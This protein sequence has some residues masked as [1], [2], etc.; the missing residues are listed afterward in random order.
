MIKR[1]NR[2]KPLLILVSIFVSLILAASAAFF[3]RKQMVHARHEG[4]RRDG[5]AAYDKGE[6]ETAMELLAKVVRR[7]P[8]DGEALLRLAEARRRVPT[9]DGQ[10]LV[11]A[12]QL[13]R[14]LVDLQPDNL[15]IRRELMSLYDQI[16]Y[17]SE[18]VGAAESVLR[19]APKDMQALKVRSKAL[20]ALRRSKEALKDAQ[21]ALAA[22]PLDVE[23]HLVALDVYGDLNQRDQCLP[24]ALRLLKAHG[25][26][27][28]AQLVAGLACTVADQPTTAQLAEIRQWIAAEL[29]E[30][31]AQA[32]GEI[33]L[34]AAAR[35][36]LMKAAQARPPDL[37]FTRLL[38][39]NLERL[40]MPAQCMAV[41]ERAMDEQ[42]DPGLLRLLVRRQFEFNRFADIEKRLAPVQLS[43]KAP[44]DL[45][46]LGIQAAALASL[47]KRDEAR[48]IADSLAQQSDNPSAQAWAVIVKHFFLGLSEDGARVIEVI[49]LA[50]EKARGNGYFWGFLGEAYLAAGESDQ[51]TAS[52][53]QSAEFC[54]LWPQ[55]LLRLSNLLLAGGQ[56][57][58]ALAVAREA[59]ILMPTIGTAANEALV[60]AASLDRA[61]LH[62]EKG[63]VLLV[64]EIQKQAPGEERTLPLHVVLLA[65]TG[66]ADEARKVVADT[67]SRARPPAE[68]T[69]L[70]LASAS[71]EAALGMEGECYAAAEKQ[72]GLSAEQVW[73]R[74]MQ[75]RA[76][77]DSAAGARIIQEAMSRTGKSQDPTWRL[78]WARYL[79]ATGDSRAVAAWTALADDPALAGNIQIQ[80]AILSASS[81]QADQPLLLRTVDRIRAITGEAAEGWRVAKMRVLARGQV[82]PEA[83]AQIM[84]LAKQVL[85]RSPDHLEARLKL[86]AACQENGDIPGAI[87]N[88][89]AAAKVSPDLAA[90]RLNLAA[91]Y[92]ERNDFPRAAEQLDQ[93][94]A[95][96]LDARQ[97]QQFAA[98]LARQGQAGKAMAVLET[99]GQQNAT[100]AQKLMLADLYRRQ[101]QPAKAES[102]YRELLK[103]PTAQ[104]VATAADFFAASG[105]ADEAKQ[106]LD[107]LDRMKLEPSDRELIMAEYYSSFGTPQQ[108]IEQARAAAR[109]APPR[110]AAWRVLIVNLVRS[111]DID[112]A[113][114]AAREAQAACG[115]ASAALFAENARAIGALGKNPVFRPLMAWII[116]G[117]PQGDADA[118]AS[119]LRALAD[120]IERKLPVDEVVRIL[121]PIADR[122][123]RC[124]P[125]QVLLMQRY[126]ELGRIADAVELAGKAMSASPTSAEVMQTGSAVY[127]SAGRWNDV[128][129][130]AQRWRELSPGRPIGADAVIAEAR[131]QMKDLA[132]AQ[133]QIEPYVEQAIA[134]P[135]EMQPVLVI[136]SRILLS[137]GEHQKA[138]DLLWPHVQRAPE[139]WRRVWL[140][141]ARSMGGSPRIAG[142]WFDRLIR[143]MPDAQ[144]NEQLIVAQIWYDTA[145][146]AGDST[147][148]DR[149]R[150]LVGELMS[151]SAKPAQHH[152]VLGYID[153]DQ[154]RPAEAEGHYRKAL[155]FEPDN[156]M[157]LNNLAMLLAERP[158][159]LPEARAMAER[160][161]KAQ[162]NA[163]AFYDTLAIVLARAKDY[164]AAIAAQ[165]KAIE[166]E[167]DA[168]EWYIGLAEILEQS[169]Q[170]PEAARELARLDVRL[171][172]Q[173]LP[174]ALQRRVA[175]LRL[176]LPTI[177]TTRPAA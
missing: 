83:R 64:G 65:R 126:V 154:G 80:N 120:A 7:T 151:R 16:G 122:A 74:A 176:R 162:P 79:E 123:P 23:L 149:I 44:A 160:A 55:P 175:S 81:I 6:M 144:S 156:V 129:V 1:R 14:R 90:I 103:T 140:D 109:I 95:E 59:R 31:A 77:G 88:L 38:A 177:A 127:A 110:A 60:W 84:E 170:A 150:T 115:D 165:R 21:D 99:I 142:D 128:L 43:A 152:F 135:D 72:F 78:M 159:A 66:R 71:R 113:V 98:L 10:H 114:A 171:Q 53:R 68:A 93:V 35:I 105:R 57:A 18:A 112:G 52:L 92:Q 56:R 174:D 22:S 111:G 153:G 42:A 145:R 143:S 164:P 173:R 91:L 46:L 39:L 106:T 13:Y 97:R 82:T 118:A 108:A 67:L 124:V 19:M 73:S 138:A 75:T 102:L 34:R 25:Q 48:T 41:L 168:P 51:A 4:Y 130:A 17:S 12:S 116:Q 58:E 131:M 133:K 27:P 15:Q 134:R 54:P 125:L 26:D 147:A 40:R 96:P 155:E 2:R 121:R 119:A 104:V 139:K 28:R 132:G 89:L 157:A 36:F 167:P 9:P 172:G 8:S 24:H 117:G 163:A 86:A 166:L 87:E 158:A 70:Q 148:A 47:G 49:R 85:A 37:M 5:M 50:L 30:L 141:L 94:H 161:V 100:V 45:D 137:R 29:P 107:L 3:V 20:A 62:E 11:S 76:E 169:G 146:A 69:L 101:N 32:G 33:N 63:L 61:R 136:W